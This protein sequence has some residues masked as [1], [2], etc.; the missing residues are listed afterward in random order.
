[1]AFFGTPASDATNPGTSVQADQLPAFIAWGDPQHDPP[2]ALGEL[3]FD[4]VLSEEHSRT[5]TVTDYAVE[6]GVNVADHV[7]PDVD[8][9]TLEVFVSNQPIN[10]TDA[11]LLPLTLDIPQPGGGTFLEGGT[12]ALLDKGLQLVG[13]AKGY[14]TQLTYQVL[15]FSADA[16]Y[17]ATAY[18][19]L[20]KLR[21][22]ATLLN[23]TT[24]RQLYQNMVLAKIGMTR[25]PQIGSGGANFSLEFKGIR[26]VSSA[27]VAA[28]LPK[29]VAGAPTVDKGKK[30]PAKAPIQKTDVATHILNFVAGH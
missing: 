15:Q 27:V 11:Q 19:T 10:S 23:V 20:T 9:V 22:T 3:H 6:Q 8:E 14:P 16:D 25:N 2:S 1:M 13:L 4:A 26:I 18:E 30:D 17:V 12:S 29:F 24:P 21:D 7:R 28:P 5:A